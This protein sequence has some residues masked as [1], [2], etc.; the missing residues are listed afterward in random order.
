[1]GGGPHL[2]VHLLGAVEDVHHGAERPAQVLR[3]LRLAGPGRAGGGAAHDQVERLGQ[4]DV[5]PAGTGMR[6]TLRPGL[7][8]HPGGAGHETWPRSKPAARSQAPSE[9][10]CSIPS[11]PMR[12]HTPSPPFAG[13]PAG[14]E[15]P[16][17]GPGDS[18][19]RGPPRRPPPRRGPALPAP[20]DTRVRDRG[21]LR[22]EPAQ[23]RARR[24]GHPPVGERGDDQPGRVPQ[25]LV[26]VLDLGVAD[27]GEAVPLLL[28]PAVPQLGLP[29]EGLGALHLRGRGQ[30]SGRR[31][32][33]RRARLG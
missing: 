1:M 5:A 15:A 29:G 14:H 3:G 8:T 32:R 30:P 22:G 10:H 21:E 26:G 31:P 9:P 12:L 7:A 28:V 2:V 11:E 18:S 23:A 33:Q 25:V 16:W 17:A 19:H 27:V 24:G 6:L 20:P 13:P 4:G